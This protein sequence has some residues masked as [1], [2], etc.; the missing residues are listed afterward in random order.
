LP[1]E[2]LLYKSGFIQQAILPVNNYFFVVSFAILVESIFIF[3]ES[4]AILEESA[5]IFE[6]S[7]AILEESAVLVE[8]A[9]GAVAAPPPQDAKATAIAK[10]KSTFFI[11]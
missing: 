5:F 11:F 9:A 6:E 1:Y 4:T 10:P 3:E 2:K 8:S 7:T